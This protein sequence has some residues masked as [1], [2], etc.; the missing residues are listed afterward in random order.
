MVGFARIH[1]DPDLAADRQTASLAAL[2]LML[3]LVVAGLFLIDRLRTEAIR[4][5]CALAG[6]VVC[7]A[8]AN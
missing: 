5:D 7:L 4:Q 1:E 8:L 6:R 2:A 3:G